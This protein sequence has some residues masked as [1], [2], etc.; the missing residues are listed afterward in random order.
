MRKWCAIVIVGL[1][2]G[3]AVRCEAKDS[4]V[5]K[6]KAERVAKKA[7]KDTSTS[8]DAVE[9]NTPQSLRLAIDDLIET[10][11]AN[12]P[13]G[14]EYLKRL[15]ELEADLAANDQTAR[16]DLEALAREA[17][18]ANPLLDFDRL[19]VRRTADLGLPANWQSN[20]SLG[21]RT[22]DNEIATLSPVHPAGRLTTLYRPERVTDFVG[23]IDLHFD[24]EKMLFSRSGPNGWSVWEI[25]V[26]GRDLRELPLI[27]NKQVDNYDACYLSD[28][29]IIF[30][31][32]AAM[33]GVP[34]VGGGAPVT[35]LFRLDT[36]SGTI[37]RLTFDQDHDWYPA[38]MDSGRV[39]YLRW[40]YSDISHAFSRILFSMN[41]DGTDQTAYYGS[42][43]YWPNAMFYARPIPGVDGKFVAIVSGHHGLKRMGELVL[44]DTAKYRFEADGVVQ[45]I[46]GR[47]RPVEPVILDNVAGRASTKFLHPW[48]LSDKYFLVAALVRGQPRWGIYLV[49]VFDNMTLVKDDPTHHL[50]EPVPLA[51]TQ[52]PLVLPSAVDLNR[53]DSLIQITDIYTGDG[54][55][56]VPRGTIKK[57]RLFTY[58]FAYYGMGGQGNRIGV[59]G[60]WDVKRIVGTVPV[61]PDGSV[62][63]RAPANTPLSLQP[64]DADGKAVQRMRSWLTAMPGETLSCVGCHERPGTAPKVSRPMALEREP[65]EI[66]PW[67]GPVR[68]FS[69]DREVQKPVI[70]KYCIGCH[71]GK[72]REDGKAVVDLTTRPKEAR[73]FKIMLG[74]NRKCNFTPSYWTLRSYVR[75]TN[76]ADNHL[77]L[78]YEFSADSSK[79]IQMLRKG[80]HNVL[81]PP[82]AWDRLITWIDLSAPAYGTWNENVGT[83]KVERYRTVRNDLLKLYANIDDD[84]EVIFDL[85]APPTEPIM[86]RPEAPRSTTVPR[87]SGWPF[88]LAEAKRRQEN[89][90]STVQQTIDLGEGVQLEMALIPS[91]QFVMGDVAGH[92]DEGPAA[93]VKIAEPFWMGSFEV[94]NAQFARFDPSHD[95]RLEAYPGNNFSVSIR[96]E[97]VNG[98]DQPVCRVSQS[99]ALAFCRWLSKTTGQQFALPSE[100]QWEYACRAGTAT[101]LNFGQPDADH[102]HHANLADVTNEKTWH[103]VHPGGSSFNDR[104]FASTD[105]G[106][107]A[108]N[109]WRLF[110]MHGNVAEWTRSPYGRY[111][112]RDKAE[113]GSAGKV[114]VRGGSWNDRVQNARSSFR[115]MYRADERVY[116]VGC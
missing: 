113:A 111:P 3:V 94:T 76:E 71:D 99:Q 92:P 14:G 19:V 96:G 24:A 1:F 104:A 91:G 106:T 21:K 27:D 48:P 98:P 29:N 51:K 103:W 82:E 85:S 11:G 83:A 18:L 44:F 66:T 32:T 102:S 61:E 20:S 114:V 100:A 13:R 75:S 34:C 54:L 87:I 25:D 5:R 64:L 17:L 73:N 8:V 81:L 42:N 30:T 43:S 15:S 16:A 86:P 101:S 72:T 110:D 38:V 10:L 70:D 31:S 89:A 41:P 59:D 58:N 53:Q 105:V 7:R 97:M 4:S 6:S 22:Y 88:D 50:L 78:P 39:M 9:I 62:L 109:P 79:L 112:Y 33:T 55:K 93:V 35:N 63:F 65:A 69:F 26:D 67:Y 28:D 115:I 95:S 77:L 12:Y 49:D 108:P 2:V 84:P 37:R 46:P 74:R 36:T 80:H 90:A 45:R 52:R 23:D 116:D 60:P 107:Y 40:E 56:D 68:G 57:L 47:G